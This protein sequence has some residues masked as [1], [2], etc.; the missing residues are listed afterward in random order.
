MHQRNKIFVSRIVPL[1]ATVE[2]KSV[3]QCMCIT[4]GKCACS[5]GEAEINSLA[6]ERRDNRRA[7]EAGTMEWQTRV[8]I[9]RL[10][11]KRPAKGAA[12]ER[13]VERNRRVTPR[14]RLAG[15]AGNRAARSRNRASGRG[16]R[17]DRE[18][19]EKIKRDEERRDRECVRITR[20]LG[21]ISVVGRAARH[22]VRYGELSC[23]LHALRRVHS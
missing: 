21:E 2:R 9:E 20:R 23:S 4:D 7:I 15:A 18:G 14:V 10:V 6:S 22:Q 3:L 17:V 13:E 19:N 12:G 8:E 16:H 5:H 11:A 1:F